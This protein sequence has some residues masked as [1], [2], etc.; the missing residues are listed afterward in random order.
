MEAL[1][2][3]GETDPRQPRDRGPRRRRRE[4]W[5]A[6]DTVLISRKPFPPDDIERAEALFAAAG[7]QAVYLP[8][9]ADPQS[10]LRAAPQRRIPRSTSGN[11]T[12]DI[13]PVSDNRPFFFYTVQPRDLWNF[14]T[15]ASQRKRRLQDQP[16]PCRCCSG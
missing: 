15:N 12:F 16:A 1:A 14:V 4:G 11:Y 6:Q 2:Q 8:G 3:L 7:M 5:G 9:A 13:S 10:V